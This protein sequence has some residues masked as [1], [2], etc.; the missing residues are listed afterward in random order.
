MALSVNQRKEL[1]ARTLPQPREVQRMLD[2]YLAR[3]GL[4]RTDFA[5][6]INYSAVTLHAFMG[7]NYGR[8]AGTDSAIRAAIVDFITAHPIEVQTDTAGRLYETDNVRLI[9]E[10]FYQ[11][12]D[13]RQARYF[14]GAPGSQ[15][16]FVLQHLVAELNRSEIAK[17]GHGR[18]AFYI[19]CREGI[20][21]AQLMKRVAE[22]TGSVS[23]CDIDRVLKNIRFDLGRRKVLYVF[24]EAQHLD[25]RCLET[26]RELHDMPPHAGLL[27][28]GSHNIEDTFNRLDMEQWASRLRKGT[29]LPGVSE[30]EAAEIITAEL[31]EQ[32]ER[33]LRVLIERCYASDLRKGR[34]HKY[35]SAR[36]L[37]YAIQAIQEKQA[38]KAKGAAE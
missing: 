27:F 5:K 32:P 38:A 3:T 19:Y 25:T 13:G 33:K 16:S 17:N 29:E 14:K 11:A 9:R 37:F 1:L 7:S 28:A 21:P 24:D 8:V 18:R 26:V 22:A 4:T 10:Q 20:R 12:L 36:N 6:R 31:G 2:D 30:S 15:K 35:I 34:Q 23:A